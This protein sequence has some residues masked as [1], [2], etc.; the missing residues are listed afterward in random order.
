MPLLRDVLIS[1]IIASFF[2]SPLQPTPA[3][4]E[5]LDALSVLLG[6]EVDGPPA[7]LIE[8]LYN[9]FWLERNASDGNKYIAC[10]RKGISF[11]EHQTGRLV[12]FKFIVK[13]EIYAYRIA[14]NRRP[15]A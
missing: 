4:L 11:S 15:G 10:F 6:Q 7:T 3:E 5:D 12:S 9:I 1:T 13:H 14:S 2:Y 8:K